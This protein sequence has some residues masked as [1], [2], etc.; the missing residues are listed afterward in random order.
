MRQPPLI[1]VIDDDPDNRD[2]VSIRLE[3]QNLSIATAVD[4][5]DGLA[6]ARELKPDL[7]ICDVAMPRM[8]GIEVVRQLKADPALPF[9]PVILLTARGDLS[10]I[11][12]GFDMGADDYLVKPAEP[13]ALAARVRAM[14]RIKALQDQVRDQ[15]TRLEAQA[16]ELAAL[17]ATLEARV[18]AQVEEIRRMSELKRFLTPQLAELIT[19][20]G[21]ARLLESHRRDIVALFCD[22]RG[23]TA[24]AETSEP[25]DVMGVLGQYHKVIGPLIHRAEGTIERFA[26]DG[27]LVF[28]N[29]PFEIP[30]PARRATGLAV[31]MRQAVSSLIQDWSKRGFRIGFGIG[32][33]QGYATLGTIGFEGRRDYAPIGTV[34]NTAARL[35]GEAGDGQI[36][37]TQR[38][39]SAIDGH[40]RLE[41]LG[42]MALKGLARPVAV[43]NVT[44]IDP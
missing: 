17:N 25:E 32:I 22:L 41:P 38:V 33:A 12:A 6:K 4:G 44:S 19:S 20:P 14:L 36:L 31:E 9:I 2:I 37:V 35:C 1:L 24:F 13:A 34:T 16:T 11:V 10:D 42:E 43:F 3:A 18:A 21:N 28:F 26:G 39:A 23:F 40:A 15:A 7:I 29:D 8:D 30:S 27:I 5:V